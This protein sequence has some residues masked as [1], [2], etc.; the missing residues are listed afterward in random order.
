MSPPRFSAQSHGKGESI[1]YGI[2][3][4]ILDSG[5]KRSSRGGKLSDWVFAEVGSARGSAFRP[6][7]M[8]DAFFT[9]EYSSSILIFFS[10]SFGGC[11]MGKTEFKTWASVY[12]NAV[13][14]VA[15]LTSLT[16]LP[17]QLHLPTKVEKAITN[18][19]VAT[20]YRTGFRGTGKA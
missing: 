14:R 4:C 13:H 5:S 3:G 6:G 17:N 2:N 9:V 1:D 10:C 19:F 7:F 11:C 20:H 8:E 15:L 16:L 12:P 18:V